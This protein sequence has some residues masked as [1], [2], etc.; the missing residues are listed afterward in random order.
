MSRD[1][2]SVSVSSRLDPWERLDELDESNSRGDLEE[3]RLSDRL[4]LAQTTPAVVPLKHRLGRGAFGSGVYR[5]DC[6]E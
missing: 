6:L 1:S 3:D 5:V 4:R 2:R